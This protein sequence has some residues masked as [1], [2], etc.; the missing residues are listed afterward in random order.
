MPD[1][2]CMGSGKLCFEYIWSEDPGRKVPNHGP[3]H[4]R[5]SHKMTLFGLHPASSVCHATSLMKLICLWRAPEIVRTSLVIGHLLGLHMQKALLRTDPLQRPCCRLVGVT[6]AETCRYMRHW[7][8]A[9]E[10]LYCGSFIATKVCTPVVH[11]SPRLLA[12]FAP[13]PQLAASS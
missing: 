9:T 12:K 10:L 2:L 4:L 7:P 6:R 13:N 8:Q 1:L 5:G 11:S 3:S